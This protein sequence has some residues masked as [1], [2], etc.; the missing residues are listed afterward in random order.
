[1]SKMEL[2]EFSDLLERHGSLL[3]DW[4]EEDFA[5]ASILL[6][7]SEAARSLLQETVAFEEALDSFTAPEPSA[8]L[9]GRILQEADRALRAAPAR[10]IASGSLMLIIGKGLNRLMQPVAVPALATWLL[11]AALGVASGVALSGPQVSEDQMLAYYGSD[12]ELWVD[13]L[14]IDTQ[15]QN[16][17]GS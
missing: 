16:G 17:S 15:I 1:M 14:A 13:A 8:A 11:V 5:R 9:R 3:A 7:K 6:D 10:S 2:A 12:T 4:P